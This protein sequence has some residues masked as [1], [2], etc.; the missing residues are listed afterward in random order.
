MRLKNILPWE[1]EYLQTF[2]AENGLYRS[3]CFVALNRGN[4]HLAE[5]ENDY[6]ECQV[7]DNGTCDNP[8]YE[9]SCNEG[10]MPI[11]E[12]IQAEKHGLSCSLRSAVSCD[13]TSSSTNL[14]YTTV[15]S[16]KGKQEK[17]NTLPVLNPMYGSSAE[18][19]SSLETSGA[20]FTSTSDHTQEVPH[21][22]NTKS[23]KEIA[24]TSETNGNLPTQ[25]LQQARKTLLFQ[26]LKA[27]PLLSMN[28]TTLDANCPSPLNH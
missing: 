19:N 18:F 8:F 9:A 17:G 16:G 7:K 26:C 12:T 11:Y 24:L 13:A 22:V 15:L 23:K 14:I 2:I 27:L 5:V 25:T 20:H 1:Q 21:L 3:V 28:S 10:N 4:S 6:T